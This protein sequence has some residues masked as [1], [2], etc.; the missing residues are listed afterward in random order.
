MSPRDSQADV[1][2]RILLMYVSASCTTNR[3]R[4]SKLITAFLNHFLGILQ[5][6]CNQD[7]GMVV[8]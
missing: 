3:G 7:K 1:A 6:E 5:A 4:E 8:Y 2:K